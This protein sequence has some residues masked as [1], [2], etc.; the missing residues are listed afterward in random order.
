M[1]WNK[2]GDHNTKTSHKMKW[3]WQYGAEQWITQLQTDP[4]QVFLWLFLYW[5]SMKGSVCRCEPCKQKQQLSQG[6]GDPCQFTLGG[7]NSSVGRVVVLLS[8]V[9]QRYGFNPLWAT[10]R[11]DFS[12][13]VSMGSK[14][15]L[16]DSINQGLV[17]AHLHSIAQT[18]KI[19]MFMS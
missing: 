6:W 8:C 14:T 16:D 11:G 5:C 3:W 1:S 17:F 10:D 19:L 18:Q 9:M 2:D 15:P 4:Q 12:L 7:W 13:G